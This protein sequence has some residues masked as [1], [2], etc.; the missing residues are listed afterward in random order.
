[1]QDVT[2]QLAEDLNLASDNGALIVEVTPGSPADKAGL[3]GGRTETGTGV[4]AGGDLIVAIDGKEMRDSREVA[5]AIAHK[6]G[7]K[8]EIKYY[9]GD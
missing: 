8:V 1:M 9:R 3:R 4:P 7:D 2:N 6:P 5:A